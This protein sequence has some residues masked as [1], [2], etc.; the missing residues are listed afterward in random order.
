MVDHSCDKELEEE[1]RTCAAGVEGVMSVDLLRTRVFGNKV[2]VDIEISADS[3]L[4]LSEAHMIADNVHDSVERQF[5]QVKHIMV[6]VNPK[7]HE[8]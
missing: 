4:P 8:E 2:Y 6:H 1:M 3:T 7:E 5:S